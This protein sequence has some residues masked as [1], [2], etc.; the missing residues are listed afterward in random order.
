MRTPL[1]QSQLGV[2]YACVTNH[3]EKTNYQNPVLFDLPHDITV[4]GVRKSVYNALIAHPYLASR[5][6]I[7]DEGVPEVESGVF[8]SLEEAVPLV[9]VK[10][11]ACP[12]VLEVIWFTNV[13]T[14]WSWPITLLKVLGRYVRYN[15]VYAIF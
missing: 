10:T 13:L 6:N 1:S 15:D 12:T 3:D 7:N 4:E 14:T 11:Y 9:P 2:Y 5:I 8:P